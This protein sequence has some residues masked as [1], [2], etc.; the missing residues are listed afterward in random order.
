SGSTRAGMEAP[1]GLP[2]TERVAIGTELNWTLNFRAATGGAGFWATRVGAGGGA[3]V[4]ISA[5]GA[6]VAD[7]GATAGASPCPSLGSG[8]SSAGVAAGRGGGGAGPSGGVE[9]RFDHTRIAAAA[10][11]RV[12]NPKIIIRVRPTPE[13]GAATGGGGGVGRS[14]PAASSGLRK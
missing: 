9:D 11:A 1:T 8:N 12:R 2:S 10:I 14:S 4:E 13:S 3:G 6:C 5:A 7:A